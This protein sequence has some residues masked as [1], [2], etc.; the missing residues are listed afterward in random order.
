MS[1]LQSPTFYMLTSLSLQTGQSLSIRL[2][3]HFSSSVY[4]MKIHRA[5]R[6]NNTR[7]V[8][9][10]GSQTVGQAPNIE[11]RPAVDGAETTS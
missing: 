2:F 11:H 5:Y 10:S 9:T 1:Q 4:T 6:N 3:P 7:Y 8:Y